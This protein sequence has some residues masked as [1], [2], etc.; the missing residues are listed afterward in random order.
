MILLIIA[1]IIIIAMLFF[2]F[3]PKS[4]WSFAVTAVLVLVSVLAMLHFGGRITKFLDKHPTQSKNKVFAIVNE[5]CPLYDD[6]GETI[7]AFEPGDRV[8]VLDSKDGKSTVSAII[9]NADGKVANVIT[10][11]IGDCA[12]RFLEED[13]GAKVKEASA[14]KPAPQVIVKTVYLQDPAAK[15]AAYTPPAPE[16]SKPEICRYSSG[17]L[18]WEEDFS[19]ND[20]VKIECTGNNIVL[21]STETNSVF[22]ITEKRWENGP[23]HGDLFMSPASRN[24]LIAEGTMGTERGGIPIRLKKGFI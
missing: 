8:L 2:R 18:E 13:A 7:G 9:T 12:L 1:V 23:G 22:Y 6:A 5:A 15:Q 10:G 11:K 14:E 24:N 17:M 20:S 21:R 4:K 16:E 3:K 19:G